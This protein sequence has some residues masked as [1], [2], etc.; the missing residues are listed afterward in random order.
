MLE[1][2]A[3]M[4]EKEILE[5][6]IEKGK[7]EGIKQGV[8]QGIEQGIDVGVQKTAINMIKNSEDDSK[9]TL[10][11]GLSVEQIGQLRDHIEKE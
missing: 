7:E 3:K 4:W 5:K 2:K 9:I 11:T 10:Y 6:G 1:T 8:Q